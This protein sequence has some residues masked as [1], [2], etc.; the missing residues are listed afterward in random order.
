ML[1]SSRCSGENKTENGIESGMIF[2]EKPEG[3]QEIN[4]TSQGRAF[5]AEK[6]ASAKALRQQ[7]PHRSEKQQGGW[8]GWRGGGGADC[9]QDLVGHCK[10]LVSALRQKP[11]ECFEQR[12]DRISLIFHGLTLAEHWMLT[13]QGG[14]KGTSQEA[15]VIFWVRGDGAWTRVG[16]SGGV[17]SG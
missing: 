2:Q 16:S 10:K 9:G 11:W 14:S 6:T 15:F 1:G 13:G 4:H 8:R 12:R 17:R 5:Q 7:L 3:D